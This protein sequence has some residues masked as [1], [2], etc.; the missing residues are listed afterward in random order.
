MKIVMIAAVYLGIFGMV[1]AS[2]LWFLDTV[3]IYTVEGFDP[4][5]LFDAALQCSMV[6]MVFTLWVE[7][8]EGK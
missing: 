1:C 7:R 8:A 3:N 6:G 5:E 2:L 4:S